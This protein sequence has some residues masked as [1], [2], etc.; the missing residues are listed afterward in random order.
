MTFM[1]AYHDVKKYGGTVRRKGQSM[2]MQ[3]DENEQLRWFA[4]C[5]RYQEHERFPYAED[6]EAKDW[7]RVE[8][9]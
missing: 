4:R 8:E 1:E 9:G 6:I 5:R 7:I 3:I 2:H